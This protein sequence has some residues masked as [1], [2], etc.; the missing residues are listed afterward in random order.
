VRFLVAGI[1]DGLSTFFEA[2]ASACAG[3]AALAG[4]T[5]L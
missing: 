3:K 2:D 5:P 1:G 4:G